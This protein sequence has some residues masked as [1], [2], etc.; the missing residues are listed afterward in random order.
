MPVR[1]QG[2][3]IDLVGEFLK[4]AAIRLIIDPAV[5]KE[6]KVPEQIPYFL[7]CGLI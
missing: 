7:S 5:D 1:L 2:A 4:S 6:L 3:V